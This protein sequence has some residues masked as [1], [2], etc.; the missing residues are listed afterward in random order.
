VSEAKAVSWTGLTW[1]RDPLPVG[2][3][4]VGAWLVAHPAQEVHVEFRNLREP[5]PWE[6]PEAEQA[7]LIREI[8]AAV[9]GPG[10]LL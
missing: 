7:R 3:W 2:A 5:D 10:P 4:P 9:C 1:P 6:S 8:H